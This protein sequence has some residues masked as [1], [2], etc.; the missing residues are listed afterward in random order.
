MAQMPD[1]KVKIDVKVVRIRVKR[2]GRS[3]LIEALGYAIERGM[4]RCDKYSEESLT[5][6]QRSLLLSEIENSFWLSLDEAGAEV[7]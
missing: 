4:N 2:D 1:L 5:D 7:E 3:I 6:G